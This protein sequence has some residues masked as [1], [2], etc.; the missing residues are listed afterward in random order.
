MSDSLIDALLKQSSATQGRD[1]EDFLAEVEA[2]LNREDSRSRRLL[3]WVPGAVVVVALLLIP[4]FLTETPDPVAKNEIGLTPP[5]AVSEENESS[6]VQSTASNYVILLRERT[7]QADEAAGRG[8]KLYAEG[9]YQGA[10]DQY[11]ASLDLLPDAPM[12]E[13]RR[14]AYIKQFSRASVLLA[15]Q[16]AKEG[17]YPE[18]IALVEEVLQPRIDPINIDA[19]RL[20]EQLNDPDH[21]SSALEPNHLERVRRL[22]LALK[23]AQGYID[24]GDV[25]RADREY[26]KALNEDPYNIAARRGIE[27]NERH[28]LNYFD[29]AYDQTRAKMLREVAEGWETSVPEALEEEVP[30]AI[31]LRS[32]A[33]V[34]HGGANTPTKGHRQEV[35]IDTATTTQ[36]RI[37]QIQIGGNDKTQDRV[38]RRELPLDY[39]TAVSTARYSA[40]VDNTWTSPAT[41]PLSTFSIDVDTASWTNIRNMIRN[42]ALS[43]SIPKDSVRIEEFINYFDWD[44]PQP[45]GDHPFALATELSACPWNRD[46]Q[47]L[48]IGIQGEN[49]IPST[50]PAANLVFL[51]DVS[52]SMNQPRKLPLVKQAISVLTEELEE[53]DRISIVVYAG[54]EGLALPTTPGSEKT[55]IERAIENLNAGGSTNGGAG[56][57]LAYRLATENF[58]EDGINRVILC[59]D[60][61][62]NVGVTG[63]EELAQLVESGADA[64]VAI[65]VLGFGQDNLNDGMLETVT[66]RGDGNYYF[67]D[68]FS[69]ARKVFLRDLMG[70]L[71]TIAKDVKIQIEFNPSEVASYRL[72][73]YA[74]RRLKKED[75]DNDEIDA[76]DIGSGHSVTALY[77]IIPSSGDEQNSNRNELR[78]QSSSEKATESA[79]RKLEELAFLKLRYK[80]LGSE[81]STLVEKIVNTT[82][83]SPDETSEDQHFASAVALFGLILRDHSSAENSSLADIIQL[84]KEGLGNDLNGYRAEFIDIVTRLQSVQ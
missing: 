26:H 48:R 79:T 32:F 74:N 52:G 50:R 47:L 66:N 19:K 59:T 68:S 51:I 45:E 3:L 9:D 28:R 18:S 11:R 15:R 77:E 2:T 38:I 35:Q 29:F 75:F 16:R 82:Q 12:T 44:Y 72:I 58:I 39:S 27:N 54:S 37:G 62:F 14:S 4:I 10:I 40:L 70:T 76:G 43:N 24:L 63:T 49:T 20:I 21:Y 25:D 67:I 41:T 23:T 31:E 46:S 53:N 56:I 69:E 17:R 81:Q 1:D 73:G 34:E 22:K 55:A 84:G 13:P 6:Q 80:R 78:Y 5:T 33:Q 65:S 64:K 7:K 36:F 57:K 30:Q 83:E 42:G 60:G 8:A 61:D 71:V